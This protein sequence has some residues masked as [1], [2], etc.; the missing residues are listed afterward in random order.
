[1]LK[2]DKGLKSVMSIL[3]EEEKTNQSLVTALSTVPLP[4]APNGT[5]TK[6]LQPDITGT[7]ASSIAT[8][9]P[10]TSIKLQS[11]L[12]NLLPNTACA[13]GRNEA[14]SLPLPMVSAVIAKLITQSSMSIPS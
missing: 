12:R 7:V 13:E 1:M 5:V 3:A 14:I 11:I 9:F 8:K 10:A 6:P 4:P 2:T